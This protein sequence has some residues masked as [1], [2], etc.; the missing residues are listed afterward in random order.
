MITRKIERFTG[1]D[2][3]HHDEES[4]SL[5]AWRPGRR[6]F[7]M[8]AAVLTGGLVASVTRRVVAEDCTK[9]S[10][11]PILGPYYLG[12]PEERYDTGDGLIVRGKILSTDCMPIAGATIVRWHA[13]RLGVYEEH[14]RAIMATKAD[15]SFEMSTIPPGKYANL[16]RHIHWYVTAP[17]HAPLIAQLQWTDDQAIEPEATFDFSMEKG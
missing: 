15:G 8:T 2:L 14:Y 3:P 4:R 5:W 16:D 6:L 17:G 7:L 11:T 9:P 10:R 13:N 1:T 12:E